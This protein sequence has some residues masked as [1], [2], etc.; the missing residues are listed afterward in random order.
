M[1]NPRFK[2]YR[3]VVSVSLASLVVL[4]F[5]G[6]SAAADP[7]IVWSPFSYESLE[8]LGELAFSAD[9]KSLF[10]ERGTDAIDIISAETLK[11]ERSLELPKSYAMN[12]QFFRIDSGR[13]MLVLARLKDRRGLT[14]GSQL[15]EI[16]AEDAVPV[17]RPLCST[18]GSE[19]YYTVAV[20]PTGKKVLVGGT[21]HQGASGE[22]TVPVVW[23]LDLQNAARER[24]FSI[25]EGTEIQQVHYISEDRVALLLRNYD[26]IAGELVLAVLKSE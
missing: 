12:L 11:L 20:S 8:I 16:D 24:E 9:G 17:I 22:V 25:S 7:R 18:S 5:C 1:F 13:R 19:R 4:G 15:S 6:Q 2:A 3:C 14:I 23:E 26:E 10:I 21:N